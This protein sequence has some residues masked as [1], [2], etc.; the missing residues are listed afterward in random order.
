MG[1]D[2]KA[3]IRRGV[4][5]EQIVLALKPYY[6]GVAIHSTCLPHMFTVW[7]D[8]GLQTTPIDVFFYDAETMI[9]DEGHDGVLLSVGYSDNSVSIL[10]HLVDKFGG[11]L[12]EDDCDDVGYIGYNLKEYGKSKP[13]TG[14]DQFRMEVS[15]LLGHDKVESVLQLFKKYQTLDKKVH[16]V[17]ESGGQ[18]SS[19]KL[20]GYYSE[21]TQELADECKENWWSITTHDVF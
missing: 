1:I 7:V 9:R 5:N 14:L 21:V 8:D 18:G 16:E 12:D 2:T 10:R 17:R 4:T 19:G 11:Y 6:T 3:I 15:T 20:V 13:L